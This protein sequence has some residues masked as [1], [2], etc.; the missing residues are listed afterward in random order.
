MSS[1]AN[2][3]RDV[4]EDWVR[5]LRTY[6]LVIA[7]GNLIW[8]T[9]HLP[10]YEIWNTGTAGENLFAV[11]HCTGGDLLIAVTSLVLAL[12]IGANQSWP[13][14][15][16]E[17]VILL[18]TGFGVAYTIFSEWLNVVVRASWAYSE[19]MPVVPIL[20]TGLSPLLECVIV[21]P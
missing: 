20:G 21:P 4:S 13:Q 17:R 3:R 14:R 2:E 16:W 12:V 6:V 18:T 1:A 11:V 9:F 5:G 10:L 19:L 15:G 7:V 8:E